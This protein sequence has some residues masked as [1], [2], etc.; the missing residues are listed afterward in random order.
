M[1]DF[2]GNLPCDCMAKIPS[3]AMPNG[4][5][6]MVWMQYNGNLWLDQC[7]DCTGHVNT[8]ILVYRFTWNACTGKANSWFEPFGQGL[9]KMIKD[10]S[11]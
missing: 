6:Q 3:F 11:K 4:A 1:S 9:I 5:K 8:I 2:V 7:H 10:A